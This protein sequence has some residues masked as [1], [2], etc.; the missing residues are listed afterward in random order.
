MARSCTGLTGGADWRDDDVDESAWLSSFA[1]DCS[2]YVLDAPLDE[3]GAHRIPA[4]QLEL[5]S[6]GA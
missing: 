1:P 6:D 4:P 5:W 2:Q 3:P